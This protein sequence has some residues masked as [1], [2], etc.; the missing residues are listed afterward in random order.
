MK[1]SNLKKNNKGF[2]LVE[3][4]VVI[5]IMTVTVGALVLSVSLI[6]GS[7]AKEA[8]RKFNSQI[9]EARTGSMSRYDEDLSIKFIAKGGADGADTDGFY[10]VKEVVTIKPTDRSTEGAGLIGLPE[11]KVI[12]QEHRYL[13]RNRVTITVGYKEGTSDE[14]YVVGANDTDGFTIKFDRATGLVKG[15]IVGGV[16]VSDAH[17]EYVDF[18]AGVRHYK[19]NF[20]EET[21]KHTIE[22]V[23]S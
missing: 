14:T 19:I 6:I 9:D 16:E 1:I 17:L 8:C 18:H 12:G 4:I 10:T 13:S 3:L 7:D 20:V 11:T 15:L 2:S 22:N 21:G 5:A 23:Q